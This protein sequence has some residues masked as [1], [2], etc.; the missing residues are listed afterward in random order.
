[1][2]TRTILNP[3][4]IDYLMYHLVDGFEVTRRGLK[5]TLMQ[6][7]ITLDE[8]HALVELNQDRL[9]ARIKDFRIV[10]KLLSLV[11]AFLFSYMQI[12]GD[13]M[14][15]RRPQRTRGRRRNDAEQILNQKS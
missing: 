2:K 13:D 10:N 3:K 15:V 4:K 11:F 12:N 14:D 6:G 8:Y 5:Q 7:A 9:I 1:M